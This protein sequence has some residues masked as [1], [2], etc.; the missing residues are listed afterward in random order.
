MRAVVS[1]LLCRYYCCVSLYYSIR[2]PTCA[3][4][5]RVYVSLPCR[6]RPRNYCSLTAYCC[7]TTVHRYFAT[8][9]VSLLL[10]LL[11]LL[12]PLLLLYY[13]CTTT[14]A[15]TTTTTTT[16]TT[17]TTT[18]AAVVVILQHRAHSMPVRTYIYTSNR[19]TTL[20]TIAPKCVDPFRKKQKTSNKYKN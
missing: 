18:T 13:Y 6:H 8:I 14:T 2:P 15:T 1:I 11:L 17:S 19:L 20:R 10:L 4:L 16:T 12:L 9:T 7:D 5:R 3:T